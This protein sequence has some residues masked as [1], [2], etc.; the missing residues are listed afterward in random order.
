MFILNP[1]QIR[2]TDNHTISVEGIK[3]IDL[4]ERAAS[5]IVKELIPFIDKNK[6]IKIFAGKGNNG[7]DA[8]AIARLLINAGYSVTAYYTDA[9]T[10]PSSDL[11]IN[12]NKLK[13]VL[14]NTSNSNLY[15]IKNES[16]I[17]EI[18]END[19]I[20]DGIFGVGLSREPEGVFAMI[21]QSINKSKFIYAIDIPSGLFCEDNS[22]NSLKYTIKAR[23]TLTLHA[24]K[25]VFMFP[26]Y[27]AYFGEVIFV[28]IGIASSISEKITSNYIFIQ[29]KHIL[30]K[31][32]SKF[33]QKGS[34]GHGLLIAGSYGKMGAAILST[35]AALKSGI[36]LQTSHIPKCGYEIIQ[37]ASPET[38]CSCDSSEEV[39]SNIPDITKYS[40]IAIGP[41]LGIDTIT[42]NA[43]S[44]LLK[45]INTPIVIDADAL[46]IISIKKELLEHIPKESILS[47]HPKEFDRL[48]GIH[49]N[50][51]KRLETQKQVSE[52]HSIYIILKGHHTSISTPDGKVYFN[53]TGNSGMATAGSGDV[54]TGILL[55][56]MSQGYLPLQS[57]LNAVYIHGLSGDIAIE[58]NEEECIIAS[59]LIE[60]LTH[61]IK[62]CKVD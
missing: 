48:F 51:F 19:Q 61:A 31:C 32:R 12:L 41:G 39:I 35:K 16:D 62:R 56:F 14:S 55:S 33:S 29:K 7:G 10:T 23:K 58:S 53:S 6:D 38:M 3:S 34:F 46:N 4:M 26:E 18:D 45:K 47:P 43:V 24:Q 36:G 20:I 15:I 57:A 21:I 37:I 22:T 9:S 17:P 8:L 52:K 11:K 5:N 1:E 42:I 2:S 40:S 50:S 25:L 44:D 60:N 28:D 13:K 30:I 59:D 54:L 27:S 49:C